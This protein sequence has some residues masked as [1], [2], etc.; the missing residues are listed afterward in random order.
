M[1]WT[2]KIECIFGRYLEEECIRTIEIDSASSLVDLHDFIQDMVDF[3][4][5]HLYEFFAGRHS[6]NRKVVFFDDFDCE[7]FEEIYSEITLEQLYPLPKG[8]KLYYNFDFGDVLYGSMI[9]FSVGYQ[10]GYYTMTDIPIGA[11]DHESRN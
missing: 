3:D 7:T 4:R 10:V 6:R 1:I 11:C 5:D 2:M 9:R 8:Y